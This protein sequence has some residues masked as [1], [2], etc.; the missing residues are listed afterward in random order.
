MDGYNFLADLHMPGLSPARL[1][2]TSHVVSMRNAGRSY[3]LISFKFVQIANSLPGAQKCR[4]TPEYCHDCPSRTSIARINFVQTSFKHGQNEKDQDH[5][6][7]F[8][9]RRDPA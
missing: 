4:K 9:G 3:V 1:L 7:C 8:S 5:G 2:I 6:T